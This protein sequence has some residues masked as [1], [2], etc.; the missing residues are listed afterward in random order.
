MGLLDKIFG[1]KSKSASLKKK[2]PTL[3]PA[4]K[5]LRK[6]LAKKKVAKPASKASKK[7]AKKEKVI[8]IITHYFP[9]VKAAVIKIKADSV[10]LGDTLHIKGHTTDFVQ[11]V[12]SL[13]VENQPIQKAKKGDEVG[14]WVK[15]KVRHNDS[16]YK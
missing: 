7:I 4:K 12:N 8:G 5:P 11:K 15:S 2:R 1:K 16:V 13:Q 3:K 10:S 6:K 9:K 14:L